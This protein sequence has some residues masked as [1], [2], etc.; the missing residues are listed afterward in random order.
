WSYTPYASTTSCIGSTVIGAVQGFSS[1][2][3]WNTDPS[4]GRAHIFTNG[5]CTFRG[6]TRAGCPEAYGVNLGSGVNICT[7]AR[8][9]SYKVNCI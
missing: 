3:C 6:Y 4:Y 7:A 8:Y 1:S 9:L 5:F 2:A